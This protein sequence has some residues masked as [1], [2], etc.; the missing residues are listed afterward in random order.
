MPRRPRIV[1]PGVPFHL[2]QRGNNRQACFYVEDDYRFY[3]IREATNGNYAL[4]SSRFQEK[5]AKALGRRVVRGRSGRPKK[6][7]DTATDDRFG[8]D[9][10]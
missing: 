2:I 4:G 5:V 10:C 9:R 1:L 7:V 3:E 8:A 6:E